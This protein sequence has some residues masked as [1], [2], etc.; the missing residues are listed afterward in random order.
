MSQEE[1]AS[2]VPVDNT[3]EASVTPPR[4]WGSGLSTDRQKQ[5][6]P[7]AKG[8]LLPGQGST[9]AMCNSDFA[10]WL[11]RLGRSGSSGG[12]SEWRLCCALAGPGEP[13]RNDDQ[14]PGSITGS[15]IL[16]D[17]EEAQVPA[18]FGVRRIR[19][20]HG[21]G[22]SVFSRLTS[23][24]GAA[25]AMRPNTIFLSRFAARKR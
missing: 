10:E 21:L 17:L 11:G 16:T 5:I 13:S 7:A 8:L 2:I 23:C 22:F 24:P 25:A 18:R 19:K 3:W 1:V 4:G 9:H 15:S 6:R 12:P 20:N 14:W